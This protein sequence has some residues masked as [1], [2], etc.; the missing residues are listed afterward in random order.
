MKNCLMC[1][2]VN[3]DWKFDVPTTKHIQG[4]F[5]TDFKEEC[6]F[7]LTIN[8]KKEYTGGHYFRIRINS[9]SD[10]EFWR[11]NPLNDISFLMTYPVDKNKNFKIKKF[12]S[13][14]KAEKLKNFK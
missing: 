2:G 7:C 1:G 9:D 8:S 3:E 14:Q 4:K 6:K 11:Y 5:Y 12:V 13:W 10:S